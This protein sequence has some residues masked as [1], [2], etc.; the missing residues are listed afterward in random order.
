MSEH[1]IFAPAD[2]DPGWP[3]SPRVLIFLL[4]PFGAIQRRRITRQQGDGLILLR[5]LFVSFVIAL[6]MFGVV[7]AV[8]YPTSPPP[9]DSPTVVVAALLF[10]GAI[11]VALTPRIEGQLDGTDDAALAASYR[12]RFFLRIAFAESAALFGFVGFF[13]TY[14]WW[15]YP[16]GLTIAAFGFSRAAP[17]RK[18]LRHDQELLA[19][20]SCFRPLVRALRTTAPPP[21]G[22]PERTRAGDHRRSWVLGSF[23]LAALTA[24]VALFVFGRGPD[25]TASWSGST[26]AIDVSMTAPSSGQKS[27][28]RI[29][30]VTATGYTDIAPGMQVTVTDETGAHL[31]TG[32]LG[33]V[34]W[35]EDN[36]C[37]FHFSVTVPTGKN[38]YRFSTEHHGSIEY[39]AA[40]LKKMHNKV[41]LD[42]S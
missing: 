29:E 22:L 38:L 26:T 15:P 28:N 30:C 37:G 41:G 23:V 19:Q 12:T 24:V 7:I 6:L 4:P 1:R 20:R 9:A 40:D 21:T 25:A 17:T 39:T 32:T 3:R 13:L 18:N 42:V 8:L 34:F 5:Q 35:V 27:S 33:P 36:R 31:A 10:L 11:G 16:V 14:D 2:D